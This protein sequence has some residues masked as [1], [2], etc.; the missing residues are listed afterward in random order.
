MP[1]STSFCCAEAGFGV[2]PIPAAALSA[3]ATMIA[4]LPLIAT[5]SADHV[6][7]IAAG[8]TTPRRYGLLRLFYRGRHHFRIPAEPVRL[9]DELTVMDLEDLHPSA[10]FVIGGRYLER[11]HETA[12]GEAMD[13]FETVLHI[14][15]RRL[16]SAVGLQ[17]I[18]D[19]LDVE[20]GVEEST[21][22]DHRVIHRL[23]RLLALRLVH[24]VDFLAHR[25][26]VAG[27]GELQGVIAFRY[28]P[29]ARRLD[30]GFG[31]SPDEPDHLGKWV[32]G[33]LVFLD[34]HRRR[35][36]EQMVDYKVGAIALCDVEHLCP[37]FDTGRRHR[38]RP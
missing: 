32:A 4:R 15:S 2:S 17:R 37:H 7:R 9:L 30:V 10:A 36:P 25:V 1:I 27:S 5:P 28:L 16:L 24:G 29:A 19:R 18:A 12:Q 21:V 20:R 22:V 26:I 3:S 8:R 13:L 23:G 35:A 33:P 34:R 11:R 6:P 31:G 38:K 14:L